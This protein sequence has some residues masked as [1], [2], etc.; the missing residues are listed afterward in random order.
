MLWLSA[1][2]VARDLV[3]MLAAHNIRLVRQVVYAANPVAGLSDDAQRLIASHQINAVL[4]LSARTLKIFQQLLTRYGLWHHHRQMHLIAA[5][6]QIIGSVTSEFAST[7]LVNPAA[8]GGY[9]EQ[10][11]G[12]ID[13]LPDS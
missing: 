10:L 5:S 1:E 7:E 8:S 2:T 11:A 3:A 13:S 9:L 4:A 6:E 12:I